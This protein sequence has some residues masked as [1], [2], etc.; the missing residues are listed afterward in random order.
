M[1][2]AIKGKF[3]HSAAIFKTIFFQRETVSAGKLRLPFYFGISSA[4]KRAVS[5]SL[6]HSR[7]ETI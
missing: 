5:P 6:S 2:I 3:F 4:K 7:S 1:I